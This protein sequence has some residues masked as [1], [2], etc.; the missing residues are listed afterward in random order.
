MNAP[1]DLDRRLG[2]WLLDGPSR[3]PE[4]TI[5]AALEHAR[6]H[7]RRHDLLAVLRRDPMSSTGFGSGSGL[8][9]MPL[10][11]ALGLLLVAALAVATVGGLFQGQPVVVPP[12]ATPSATGTPLATP[13]PSPVATPSPTS[14][15]VA[16]IDDIGGTAFIEITDLSGT[17]TKARSGKES[18]GPPL[19]GDIG[20]ADAPGDPAAIVLGW[21]GCPS[22]TRYV[23]TIAA[24]GRT[25][26]IDQPACTGD[27]LGVARVLVLTF[28]GPVPAD[29][30]KATIRV[31]GG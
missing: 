27:T 26:S 5:V 13:S 7:P 25:M 22:D 3:A 30:V 23:M 29:E 21:V 24:D 2:D 8:R 16:F 28:D 17:L 4:R 18:E 31:V 10:A 6:V 19:T 12:V 9:V 20:V 11:A 15:R 14:I 1:H